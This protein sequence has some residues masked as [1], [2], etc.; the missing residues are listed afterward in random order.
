MRLAM[1]GAGYVGLVSGACLADFGYEVVC[2]DRDDARIANLQRG[3]LPLYEPQLDHMVAENCAAGRLSFS[4]DLAA[5][6][7]AAD[8]VFI[9]VGTPPSGRDGDVDLSAVYAAAKATAEA[10]NGFTVVVTKSTVPPGTGDEVEAIIRDLR[11]DADFAVASNPEFLREGVAVEEFRHPDR[12]V[13]GTDDQRARDVLAEL[14]RPLEA[15]NVPTVF[16]GRRTAELIKYAAN[17]FLATKIGFINEIANLCEKLGAD[18]ADV[19]TGLGLDRRIG[20]KFLN[21]GPGYGGSCLPKDVRGLIRTA[22]RAGMELGIV[23]AVEAVNTHRR[24][25]I[26]ARVIDVVGGAKDATIAVLGLTFKPDTDDIRET[27]ALPMIAA[28]QDAGAKV[29]AFDPKGMEHARK[30]TKGVNFASDP[31]ECATGADALVILTDWDSFRGLDLARLRAVMRRPILVDFRNIYAPDDLADAGFAY[32]AVGRGGWPSPVS[33]LLD[34]D[35]G[36]VVVVRPGA[37]ARARSGR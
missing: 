6:V 11:P 29:R 36:R 13:I 23:S 21:P 22:E 31:Y 37:I 4:T 20:P 2:V 16:T 30:L 34:D 25:D 26:A 5:A 18:V 12:V 33:D 24:I 1:I 10:L 15:N 35:S 28:L 14:Y 3:V 8:V 27:P 19:S 7:A 9:A 32:Y 17:A